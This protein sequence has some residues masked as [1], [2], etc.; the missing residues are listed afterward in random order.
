VEEAAE[1]VYKNENVYADTS[2]LVWSP[3]LP[4]YDA[5]VAR[6]QKRLANAIA[7]M[8][9]ADRVLYGS[10]WPLESITLAV[11]MIDGLDL[12]SSAKAQILGGNARKLFRLPPSET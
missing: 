7:T 12:P 10:D 4:F 6:A 1:V 3:R 5:M 9:T 2:G 11:R 8:G